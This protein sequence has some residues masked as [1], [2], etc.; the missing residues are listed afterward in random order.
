VKVVGNG[1]AV[2]LVRVKAVRY[3]G[4]PCAPFPDVSKFTH[5]L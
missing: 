3:M 2:F 5:V 4:Q 1:V